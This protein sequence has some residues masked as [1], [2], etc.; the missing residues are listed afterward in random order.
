MG[1]ARDIQLEANTKAVVCCLFLYPENP[2]PQRPSSAWD[3]RELFPPASCPWGGLS[4]FS[5]PHPGFA[6]QQISQHPLNS[7]I[8]PFSGTVVRTDRSFLLSRLCV[9]KWIDDTHGASASGLLSK[10]KQAFIDMCAIGNWQIFF[11]FN[12]VTQAG[13]E[14]FIF[15][16]GL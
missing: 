9:F 11:K 5:S 3:A 10:Y 7:T 14:I 4:S 8:L 12:S 6:W 16:L 15:L 1:S 13:L 2:A